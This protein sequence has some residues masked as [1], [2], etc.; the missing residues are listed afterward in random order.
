MRGW[1]SVD[2][3]AALGMGSKGDGRRF[4]EERRGRRRGTKL[5]R[6]RAKVLELI[7]GSPPKKK[8]RVSHLYCPASQLERSE[9]GNENEEETAHLS[10]QKHPLSIALPQLVLTVPQLLLQ[11]SVSLSEVEVLHISLGERI[12][13]LRVL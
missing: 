3:L 4:L 9:T 5:R 13:N 6:L 8:T 7:S 12:V 2:V 1:K 10:L 11:D